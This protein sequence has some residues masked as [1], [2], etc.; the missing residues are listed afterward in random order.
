MFKN[1]LYFLRS[2]RGWSQHELADRLG[3]ADSTVSAWETGVKSPRMEMAFK[4]ADLFGVGIGYL[5]DEDSEPEPYDE[6][7]AAILE[8]LGR[9]DDLKILFK[10]TGKLTEEELLQVVNVLKA[11]LPR[12]E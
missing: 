9:N 6:D 1:K 4:I 12:D 8:L 5:L 11:L 2:G 7:V 10:K 3:V